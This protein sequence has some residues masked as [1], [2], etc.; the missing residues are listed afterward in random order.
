M[1]LQTY[2][3]VTAAANLIWEMA[4]LPLY[5]IWSTGTAGENFFAVVH[6]TGGDLL[7]ALSTLAIALVFFG[8]RDWPAQSYWRVASVS[9]LL[10]IAYTTFS[11][12]LNIVI[13]KSWEYSNLMPVVSVSE[14]EVGLSPLLQWMFVPGLA[15]WLARKRGLARH[16]NIQVDPP[17]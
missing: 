2:L 15:L 7:I 1:T 3:A 10:G 11:E 14:F 16:A 4:H 5:S 9:T 6:C 17:L 13:R 8:N 12:W